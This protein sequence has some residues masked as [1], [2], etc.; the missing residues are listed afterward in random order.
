MAFAFSTILY[1]HLPQ[2]SLRLACP[3]GRRYGLTMFRVSNTNGVDPAYPPVALLS[4]CPHHIREHPATYL[5]VQAC[6]H[7]WLVDADDV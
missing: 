1:P 7:L 6:Q 5:L 4:M 2:R 3:E